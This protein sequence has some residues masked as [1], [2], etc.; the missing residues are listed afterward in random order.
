MPRFVGMECEDER[1]NSWSH[2][3]MLS[4]TEIMQSQFLKQMQCLCVSVKDMEPEWK[5]GL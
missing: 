4:A 2:A 3:E 5:E 1:S